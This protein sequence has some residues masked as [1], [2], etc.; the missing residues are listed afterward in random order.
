MASLMLHV[1]GEERPTI[2]RHLF[3]HLR[4]GIPPIGQG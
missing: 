1:L 3:S 4:L 2:R